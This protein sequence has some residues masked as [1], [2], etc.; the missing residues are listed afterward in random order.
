MKKRRGGKGKAGVGS[1]MA[2]LRW[3]KTTA[4]ERRDHAMKMVEAKKRK[5][6]Q[7]DG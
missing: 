6:E 7:R 4:Q 2:R 5:R 1:E 3:A